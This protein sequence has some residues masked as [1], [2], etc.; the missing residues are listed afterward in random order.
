MLAL[1]S[2]LAAAP[3]PL[4]ASHLYTLEPLG[5]LGG[6][7]SR[8]SAINQAGHV[9]GESATEGGSVQ[10][11]LWT[12]GQGLQPLGTLGGQT[13]RAHDVN[14]NGCVVGEATDQDGMTHA[15]RW[16]RE[17]G[18]EAL[19]VPTDTQYST[20]MA[21]NNLGW[22]VGALENEEGMHAVAWRENRILFLQRLP[23]SG[24]VQPLD[25]NNTGDVVGHIAIGAEETHTSHAY[26]FRRALAAEHLAEFRLLSALGGSA[27]TALSDE[28]DAAGYVLLDSARVRA[29]HYKPA[30][31]L[32]LLEDGD[33]LYAASMDINNR[34]HM[35]GSIV[36]SY[37]AD[38]SACL[39]LNGRRY[40]LNEVTDRGTNWWLVQASSIN[41]A[42]MIT[43][44]GMHGT[45]N[46]AFVLHPVTGADPEQW[47]RVTLAV[48]ETDGAGEDRFFTLKAMIPDDLEVRQVRF[49]DGEELL[50]AVEDPP[51]EWGLH[52][53]GDR[54]HVFHADTTETSGRITRSPRTRVELKKMP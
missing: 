13:S 11:F 8:A 15:F 35:T 23:G 34:G 50:G 17:T 52:V 22:V 27:A 39:W 6:G 31:G 37:E 43:G 2:L 4:L 26:Y 32:E 45:A 47:S 3:S 33:A 29:F 42:G 46:E 7:E 44:Y 16:T 49:W 20:A 38:E 10:A 14:D 30:S 5:H 28:G 1:C 19:P 9:A 40:D 48:Q 51:Y 24:L 41:D 54:P 18:M 25:I 12:P 36:A 21:V 53:H